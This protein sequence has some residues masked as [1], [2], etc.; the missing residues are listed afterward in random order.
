MLK[1]QGCSS[2]NGQVRTNLVGGKMQARDLYNED[3]Q[4]VIQKTVWNFVKFYK[5][6][7]HLDELFSEAHYAF[8]ECV[9]SYDKEKGSKFTTWVYVNVWNRMQRF[10]IDRINTLKKQKGCD[11]EKLAM[12]ERFNIAMFMDKLSNDAATAV[13]IA[14]NPTTKMMEEITKHRI[15][16]LAHRTCVQIELAKMGWEPKRIHSA[17]KEVKEVL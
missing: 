10:R 2:D 5:G 12:P 11:L 15:Q 13:T 3:V 9:E 6:T 17:F 14:L 16:M 4:K 1:V 7:R 8:M